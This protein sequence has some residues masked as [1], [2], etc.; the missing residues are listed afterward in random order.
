MAVCHLYKFAIK[1]QAPRLL[2]LDRHTYHL[3]RCTTFYVVA[4]S[5]DDV[6]YITLTHT[7]SSSDI[8]RDFHPNPFPIYRLVLLYHINFDVLKD[9]LSKQKHSHIRD[10]EFTF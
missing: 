5:F 4:N 10:K 8:S 3:I 7:L 6:T 9:K 1:Y 2:L